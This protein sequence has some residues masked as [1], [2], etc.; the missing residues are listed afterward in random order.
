M[1]EQTKSVLEEA[2]DGLAATASNVKRVK[3][4][5][6]F[7]TDKA[8]PNA[9]AKL[10][11]KQQSYYPNKLSTKLLKEL[12]E[13]AKTILMKEIDDAIPASGDEFLTNA[14]FY[15][16]YLFEVANKQD[17]YTFI[18]SGTGWE[19]RVTPRI[20]FDTVA[21]TLNDYARGIIAVRNK[22]DV[23]TGEKDS[24]RGLLATNW[25]FSNVYGTTRY[26]ST[27]QRRISASSKTA[28]FWSLINHGS[29][30]MASDRGDGSFNPL[31]TKGANFIEP[32]QDK[33]RKS[34]NNVFNSE[35]EKWISEAKLLAKE[36][37]ETESVR[38]ELSNYARNLS[39]DFRKNKQ[40]F[41]SLS[42][43]IRKYVDKNRLAEAERLYR[44]GEEFER[45]IISRSDAGRRVYLTARQAEG[46]L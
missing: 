1:F 5:R 37:K 26:T 36:I 19:T 29:V 4:A 15:K 43:K 30:G 32:A 16:K 39:T 25:W 21:G 23:R 17:I 45:I 20:D 2:K 28:P 13:N 8:L 12:K 7:L 33:L 42:P 40:L 11:R 6:D 44:A 24:G 10:K 41:D 38:D 18:V 35:K 14:S 9:K 34:F 3:E 46:F 27:V 31:P 22:K